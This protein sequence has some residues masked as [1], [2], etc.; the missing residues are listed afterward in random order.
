MKCSYV[1]AVKGERE[2]S[3]A[4]VCFQFTILRVLKIVTG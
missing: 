4:N 2:L 3:I 1:I